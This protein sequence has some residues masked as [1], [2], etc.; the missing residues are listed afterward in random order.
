[1]S[2]LLFVAQTVAAYAI[3][4]GIDKQLKIKNIE[5]FSQHLNTVIS[6][7]IDLFEEKYPI[8]EVDGKIK[9]YNSQILLEEL[10]KF[11]L[12][13]N[14]GYE[15]TEEIIKVAFNKNPNIIKPTEKQLK[16]FFE[17]F[18]SFIRSDELLKHLEIEAF[19]K[20]AIFDILS[21]VEG[22]YNFLEN[23][24]IE[25]IGLLEEKYR[26]DIEN[27]HK[28][29]LALKPATALKRLNQLE[30]Q[31]NLN[32]KH[33]SKKLKASLSFI[34]AICFEALGLSKDSLESFITA[35]KLNPE[36]TD[37]LKK[38]CISY[39]YL[40]D[41]KYKGLKKIIEEFDE[42][43]SYCWAISVLESKDIISFLS[44]SVS[45]NVLEK[46][47]FKRLIFNKN[48]KENFVSNDV[49]LKVLNASKNSPELPN[50]INYNNLHNYIFIL[51]VLWGEFQKANEIPFIGSIEKNEKILFL[52]SLLKILAEEIENGELDESYNSIVFFYYW[53]ETEVEFSV[54]ALTKLKSV[55]KSIKKVDSFKTML[56]ANA[57][58]KNNNIESAVSIIEGF[59]GKMDNDLIA[60]K[61]F[62]KSIN[63]KSEENDT[64]DE[65]IKEYFENIELV[66][67]LY[68][69]NICD[70]LFLIIIN[71]QI[72]KVDLVN[73]TNNLSFSKEVYKGLISLLINTLFKDGNEISIE[74][75]NNIKEGVKTEKN[76]FFFIAILYSENNYIKECIDFQR[77]YIEE[78]KESRDL[79]LYIKS[80]NS[81]KTIDQLKLLQLLKDWRLNY[82]FN[83]YLL[84]I[85]I[86]LRQVL[87]DWEE[88]EKITAYG[89]SKLQND[90]PLFTL[91]I[92][93]LLQQNNKIGID[94][95]VSKINDF[96]FEITE[97]AIRAAGI[98]IHFDYHEEG[99]EIL[100][101][102]AI[103]KYD[104]IARQNYFALGV[105]FPQ[106]YFLDYE[107]VIINS[108]VKFEI[109][110][111][112]SIEPVNNE[113]KS[114]SII[115][116][117]FG[118]KV[119]ETFMLNS[120]LT[121]KIKKVTII[122]VMNKYLALSLEIYS[123][124]N[125]PYSNLPFESIEFESSD[126]KSIEKALVDNFGALES[127]KRINDDKNLSGFNSFEISF[128]ELVRF[129]F[130]DSFIDG[131]YKLTS[132]HSDGFYVRPL[133]YSNTEADI[134]QYTFVLDFSS[135]LL[136]FGLSKSLK[137][138]FDTKFVISK[139]LYPFIERLIIET[140]SQRG[141][142]MSIS[143]NNNKIIPHF[144]SE[145]FHDNRMNFLSEMK[146]W[147]DMN[148]TAIIPEEKISVIRPIHEKGKMNDV[149][150]FLVD[151][152]LLAQ[153]ENHILLTDDIIYGKVFGQIDSITSEK[154]LFD[155]FLS[156]KN[157]ILEYLI[158]NRYIG[159][160][161]NSDVLYD[162]FINQNK[163]GLSH[164]YNY[165]V[166]NLS[167]KENF[168]A[169]NIS[170]VA[171]FMKKLALSPMLTKVKYQSVCTNLLTML[172]SSF[173]DPSIN[174]SI[175]K[176]IEKEFKLMGN[177]LNITLIALT[178]AININ[179]KRKY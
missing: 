151:N 8:T 41:E 12:F 67:N 65:S 107:S 35:Y 28:E 167:L 82:S 62:C 103:N 90:E 30:E 14:K 97:N 157:E 37:Y 120:P 118:K 84:R 179:N 38:A 154:F 72:T 101:Q 79:F 20:T 86:D 149:L 114:S 56:I 168:R 39:Y 1:M 119:G 98:L 87:K 128:T 127:E 93:S 117:S 2:V 96:H 178:D 47:H 141:S 174:Y 147:L 6:K 145:D 163:T 94:N 133:K 121:N 146:T 9:F 137:I 177:Y 13:T 144:Y 76:L 129:N 54:A 36:N 55:Y 85:E 48:L 170:I 45:D 53:L 50:S 22:I 80:I 156:R 74:S 25:V 173:P 59:D 61:S 140:E 112:L 43:D 49:L 95:L 99:L 176:I 134:T 115:S 26:S 100:Y 113:T 175:K 165:A 130:S 68:I 17:I 46:D 7:S 81:S 138:T 75:I 132:D 153:R 142:E 71:G 89:L 11:R 135:F 5:A 73:I 110:G 18:D 33:V 52:Y 158:N 88:I 34:K 21:K 4:K 105:N 19:H 70:Y 111:H 51:N 77:S 10:L 91:H 23:Q 172:V 29:I 109:D 122:R 124:V 164:V 116:K 69:Q 42:Y 106:Q 57:L 150:D 44:G 148:T 155:F 32:S 152:V 66:N 40:N 102:K 123:E 126:I 58:Q 136:L 159:I 160:S 78:D 161:I 3:N 64:T 24:F 139:N 63:N 108:F 166:R 143:I 171:E 31:I 169:T 27:C 92:V 16:S 83:D 131:Y 125:S 162:S 104:S 15:I 60:L